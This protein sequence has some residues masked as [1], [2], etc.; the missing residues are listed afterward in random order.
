MSGRFTIVGGGRLQG[1]SRSQIVCS[2][3][4]S[5][6]VQKTFGDVATTP[7][8]DLRGRPVGEGGERRVT[9]ARRR[10]AAEAEHLER[11]CRAG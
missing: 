11:E 6:A 8:G 4:A 1:A 3:S 2:L 7:P 10:G 9:R 5:S